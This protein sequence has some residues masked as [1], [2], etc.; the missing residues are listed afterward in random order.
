MLVSDPVHFGAVGTAGR[1]SHVSVLSP[2]ALPRVLLGTFAAVI[3][4]RMSL[5]K[6]SRGECRHRTHTQLGVRFLLG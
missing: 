1:L 6:L 4:S 2:K 3:C 5:E